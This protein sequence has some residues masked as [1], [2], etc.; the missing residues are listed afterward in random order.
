MSLEKKI[1]TAAAVLGFDVAGI[2]PFTA[3]ARTE[4]Y[5]HWVQQEK[6][7]DMQ[8]F[9]RSPERRCDPQ[10]VWPQG[11]S[12]LMLGMNYRQPE[13]PK[14]L[15]N[16]P[17]RGRIS[18]YAWG[19]DY[20]D[21][22][23]P[24]LKQLASAIAYLAG[25]EVKARWYVDTGPFLERNLAEMASLGFIGKNTLL[26]HPEHGSFHF[27]ATLL[28][29]LE[30]DPDPVP[31]TATG[32][33]SCVGCMEKCPTGALD[34]PYKHDTPRCI[35]YLT[36]EHKGI[37]PRELRP[38]MGNW[39]YGCD[40]CQTIC[41]FN[42][43]KIRYTGEK[44]YMAPSRDRQIP[45]LSEMIHLNDQK[46]RVLFRKSAVKRI[47]RN[48][49]LRNVAVAL[50]NWESPETLPMLEQLLADEEP[51]IRIHAAWA[52]GRI[53]TKKSVSCLDLA[54]R[55]EPDLLVREEIEEALKNSTTM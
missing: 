34:V 54:R 10:L 27:L 46:F 37:I 40:D 38:L 1:K 29:D 41:P 14:E 32:C 28:L 12:I 19:N 30:L 36:I 52:L 43:K 16:D 31:E 44:W 50:G 4:E 3:P 48:R 53:G 26:L 7:G 21:L 2:V 51:L 35:S 55:S 5:L 24:R 23:I 39:I 33:G 20:H 9:Y 18:M 11:K 49:F 15:W 47:K 8:W 13:V 22:I 6:P 25:R 45:R 17:S 42:Q